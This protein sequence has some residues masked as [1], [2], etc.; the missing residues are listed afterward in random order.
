MLIPSS[1][2]CAPRKH[3]RTASYIPPTTMLSPPSSTTCQSPGSNMYS[4][5]R[6]LQSLLASNLP[7]LSPSPKIIRAPPHLGSP[8]VLTSAPRAQPKKQKSHTVHNA[9][10]TKPQPCTPPR[11][12]HN[13]L[14]RRRSFGDDDHNDA[15][16]LDQENLK[17]STPKRQRTC[18]P[19]LPL[20]L[21]PHDFAALSKPTPTP[22][23]TPAAKPAL[24]PPAGQ[25]KKKNNNDDDDDD[26][27]DW[28]TGDDS[29]LVALILNKLRLRPSDWDECARELGKEKDSI[30]KR[31]AHLLGDGEVGLRRGSGKRTRGDVHKMVFGPPLPLPA[32]PKE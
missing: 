27:S 30:G 23:R 20:G 32:A 17:P 2:D 12:N 29:A 24:A 6:A 25:E 28:S 7:A 4:T 9:K 21:E 13:N 11:S 31:W 14:K 22:P 16:A 8:I 1:L 15:P 26:E 3:P 5:C 10:I 18:P 19:T